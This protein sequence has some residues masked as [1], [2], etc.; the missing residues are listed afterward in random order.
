M[1]PYNDVIGVLQIIGTNSITLIGNGTATGNGTV[2]AVAYVND[3]SG[4]ADTLAISICG[5]AGLSCNVGYENIQ[6]DMIQLYPVPAENNL[7]IV[8]PA[9]LLG[10]ISILNMSGAIVHTEAIK[11][12][13]IKLDVATLNKGI[14][15]LRI[16]TSD[17]PKMLKFTKN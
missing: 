14:Y 3:G 4:K 8:L 2:K 1:Q 9:D 13:E 16:D 17:G 11:S 5:Q 12:R 15:L 6:A 10:T 7:N